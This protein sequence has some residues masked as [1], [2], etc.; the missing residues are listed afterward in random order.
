MKIWKKSWVGLLALSGMIAVGC[1][2]TNAGGTISEESLSYRNTNLYSE[3]KT[4]PPPVTYTKAAPGTAKTFQRSF[5]NAPPM[6]P[7]SVEGLLPITK[8][9]N[10]CL[11]CHMPDVAPSMKATPIPPSHF[12]NFRPHTKIGASGEVI[13]E[14]KKVDNTSDI[15]VVVKK[16]NKLYQGRFNCSQCHAPQAEVTPLVKNKFTPD[17]KSKDAAKRSNLLDTLNEGVE[18]K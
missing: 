18:I 7:H 14:G 11:G 6:I 15:Q 2:A 16:Q 5:E 10:A 1:A 12:A 9:N 8:S 3:D 17:F 4:L 13:K